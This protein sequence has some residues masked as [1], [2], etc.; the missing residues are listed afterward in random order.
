MQRVQ[1]PHCTTEL[2]ND[3]SLA[4][5][6]ATCAACGGLFEMPAL[7]PE[8]PVAPPPEPAGE[9]SH[10]HGLDD[11]PRRK[12]REGGGSTAFTAFT[13][14]ALV[15]VPLIVLVVGIILIARGS[16]SRKDSGRGAPVP[17]HSKK[18]RR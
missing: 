14:T 13:V 12:R 4:G 3:G 16:F 2:T 1:C 8:A 7:V 17:S 5:Q 11:L 15:I 10:E 6:L 18:A 9:E